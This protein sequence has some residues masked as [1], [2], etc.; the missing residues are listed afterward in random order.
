MCNYH[1]REN[2][3]LG[4]EHR[5]DFDTELCISHPAL[6]SPALTSPAL[7]SPALT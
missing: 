7:I 4:R 3:A 6:T 2:L 1:R 5:S